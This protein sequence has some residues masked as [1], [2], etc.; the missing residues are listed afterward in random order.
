MNRVLILSHAC[1]TAINQEFFATLAHLSGWQV[2]VITPSRWRNDYG[3]VLEPQRWPSFNGRLVAFPVWGSGNIPLH[4]YRTFFGQVLREE[5]PDFLYAHHEAYAIATWQI[6]RAAARFHPCPM[7]FCTWQNLYKNYPLPFRWLEQEVYHRSA[8]AFPGSASAMAVLRQKGFTRPCVQV[9]YGSDPD[10]YHPQARDGDLRRSWQG[11]DQTVILG[12]LGRLVEEKGLQTLLKVLATL[13]ELDWRLVL[14]GSGDYEQA[15]RS[16]AIKL[17]LGDRLIWVGF[18]PHVEAPKYLASFDLTLL[19]SE[20]RPNW[21]EQ[22]GR[23]IIE[24]MAC[25]TPVLGSDSGEIPYLIHQTGGGM[26]FSEGD[27]SELRQHLA[28]LI[29]NAH[30]RQSLGAQGRDYVRIHYTHEAIAQS[31]MTAM[32]SVC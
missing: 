13:M 1:V 16:Q 2:T 27:L 18:V 23:V 3:R 26:V 28:E 7:A 24:S 21:K 5:R 15:L 12:Y 17:G 29:T 6:Y 4:A 10:L 8:M 9:P 20:T 25:G 11:S 32:Q 30:R 19:P 14:V 31:M 22:F